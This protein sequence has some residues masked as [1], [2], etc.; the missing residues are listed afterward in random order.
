MLDIKGKA[1]W[2]AWNSVRGMS[3]EDAMQQYV[4]EIEAQAHKYGA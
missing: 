4:A 1:K 3:K 2:D